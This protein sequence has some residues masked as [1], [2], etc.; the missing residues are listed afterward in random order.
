MRAEALTRKA[1]VLA[2][3][4]LWSEATTSLREELLFVA[5]RSE[6][7]DDLVRALAVTAMM[8]QAVGDLPSALRSVREIE[9]ITRDDPSSRWPAIP[10]AVSG[11]ATTGA[12]ESARAFLKGAEL[13]IPREKASLALAYGILEETEERTEQALSHYEEA[14]DLWEAL[15]N[16]PYLADALFGVGRCLIVLGEPT[17]AIDRLEEAL[18]LFKQLDAGPS[19]TR[20]EAWLERARASFRT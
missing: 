4:G 15:G 9:E 1:W 3:R 7:V 17:E 12:T 18:K 13:P 8:D 5:R 2:R 14:V 11:M 19:V 6:N 16:M 20:T 10:E